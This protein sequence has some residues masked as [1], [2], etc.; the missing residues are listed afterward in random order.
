MRCTQAAPHR[1][2]PPARGRAGAPT[3]AALRPPRVQ[4][5]LRSATGWAASCDQN[6]AATAVGRSE[7]VTP[8]PSGGVDPSSGSGARRS[9]ATSAAS[10]TAPAAWAARRARPRA[11]CA[12]TGIS[13]SAAIGASSGPTASS[14]PARASRQLERRPADRQHRVDG[15]QT[16]RDVGERE[17]RH[18]EREQEPGARGGE[19]EPGAGGG[20]RRSARERGRTGSGSRPS[21]RPRRRGRRAARAPRRLRSVGRG[22]VGRLRAA[23]LA[24]ALRAA[25]GAPG[26]ARSAEGRRCGLTSSALATVS[27]TCRGRSGRSASSGGAPS[28]IRR[29]VSTRVAAPERVDA[30]ERLPEQHPDRPRRRR[31]S[32]RCGRAAAPGRCRR[33]CPGCRRARSACRT[34]P[35][36]PGRSRAAGRRCSR[37]RRAGRS[38]ASRRGARSPSRARVRA[39]RRSAPP[40]RLPPDRRSRPRGSPR[41]ACGPGCT[42]RRCRRAT[43]R[44]PS[45]RI[46]WQRGC[47][48]E[49]AAR[50]SRSAR[51]P[52]LPSRA[53]IFSETSRPLRSSRASQT[54]PMPP[55]PE[56][57]ERPVPAEKEV[58]GES[59][60][61]HPRELLPA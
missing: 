37:T 47:R 35:S 39:P 54:W 6:A 56:R 19:A 59:R 30:D 43:G 27:S 12:T 9:P 51:W 58:A 18:G 61:G 7:P 20:E 33:A 50:A 8:S 3:A 11:T 40:P 53:T 23:L 48:R 32:W 22:G 46:R 5:P 31:R 10:R 25:S 38:T 21:R 24:A 29:E 42:R 15:S 17:E 28:W 60:G 2:A 55:E 16:E 49:A 45:D 36:A 34:P 44:V 1:R 52:A 13:V 41:A 14:R 57:L 4:R 26:R